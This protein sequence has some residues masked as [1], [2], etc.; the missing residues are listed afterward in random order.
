[1]TADATTKTFTVLGMKVMVDATTT[2][3]DDGAAFD[4]L[5]EGDIIEVSGYFDGSQIV[6]SRIE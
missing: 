5:A 1:M 3:F 6:A 4:T 2:V